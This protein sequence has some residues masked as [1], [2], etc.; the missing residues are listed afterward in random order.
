MISAPVEPSIYTPPKRE[1]T[2][3]TS[4]GYECVDFI[5]DVLHETPYP[6]QEWLLIHALELNADGSYRFPEV[7]AGMGRQ[8]GKTKVVEW[9]AKWWLYVDSDRH[10]EKV[11]PEEFVV[12]GVAQVLDVAKKP[13]NRVVAS[14]DP[15]PPTPA[16]ERRADERF[17]RMTD[18]V[19]RVNGD[20]GIYTVTGASYVPRAAVNARGLTAARTIFDELREQKTEDGW[21]AVEPLGENVWSSQL[22]AISSAG[23]Y[24]SITLRNLYDEAKRQAEQ[25]S[26]P[27]IAIFWW[28]CEDTHLPI[29]DEN[30]ILAANPT[31]GW[32]N[33][34]LDA[35]RKKIGGMSEAK[36]R[37]EYLNQWVTADVT[38]YIPADEWR[39]GIDKGSRI[40][41]GSRIVLSAYVVPDGTVGWIAAA[42]RREDGLPHVEVVARR[43]GM[44]WIPNLL[45]KIKA[46][47]GAHEIAIRTRGERIVDLIDDISQLGMQ[48]DAVEGPKFAASVGHLRSTVREHRLRHPPQPAVDEAI[49]AAVSRKLGDLDVWDPKNSALDIGGVIAETYALYGLE[50]FEEQIEQASVSAYVSHGLMVV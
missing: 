18:K 6:W 20:E 50:Q 13:Y 47:T 41:E 5:R 30:A 34:T 28:G 22:W 42:G 11:K 15:K 24:R 4:L 27:S 8:N 40:A 48:I 38:S 45:G 33:K 9:L 23:D 35:V 2:P 44:R 1:L 46:K 49:P 10:P 17:Q 3:D 37:A 31:I 21:A 25:E 36:F 16:L 7:L 32:G 39:Q 12:L 29:D 14:V 19:S 43:D 26:D